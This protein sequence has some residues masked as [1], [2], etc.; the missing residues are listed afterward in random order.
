[1]YDSAV[2]SLVEEAYKFLGREFPG[3]DEARS[4]ITVRFE[5]PT[6]GY[7]EFDVIFEDCLVRFTAGK[8][9]HRMGR[10][11]P[12]NVIV[13]IDD[14]PYRYSELARRALKRG[15]VLVPVDREAMIDMV[16]NCY[17]GNI[18]AVMLDHDI[19]GTD[20]AK[21]AKEHLGYRSHP[22]IIT[23][24]NSSGAKRIAAVLDEYAVPHETIPALGL[25]KEDR[26]MATLKEWAAQ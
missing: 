13:A 4:Q 12:R 14:E 16:L 6:I 8:D 11:P 7:D 2:W 18:L 10:T 21:I 22:V 9:P 5:D 24:N 26:W 19:P 25:F 17:R 3:R 20:G 23:S 15:W 1:M